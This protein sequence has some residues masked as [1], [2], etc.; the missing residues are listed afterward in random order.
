MLITPGN[1]RK[2]KELTSMI[3]MKTNLPGNNSSKILTKLKKLNGGYFDPYPFVHSNK[4]NGC[5]FQDIDGNKFLDFG[6]QIASNPLGYNH[7]ELKKVIKKYSNVHP[8]KY[9][10]QD[11]TVKEHLTLL[12][13]LL[14]ITPKE[15]NA[16]F[17]IN[18]GA[19]A[20]ENA[21]KICMRKREKAKFGI[22]FE[23]S[24]HGRCYDEETE[25][26]TEDGW[27]FFKDLKNDEK[28]ATLNLKNM[29]LEY[30]NPLAIVSYNY[31]GEMVKIKNCSMDL[32]VTPNHMMLISE[33]GKLK[34]C[35]A[36]NLKNNISIPRF[37]NW[38][39]AETECFTL[40][41]IEINIPLRNGMVYTQKIE[42]KIIPMDSW[43]KFFGIWLAEGW[44]SMTPKVNYSVGLAQKDKETCE[45]IESMLNETG[46]NFS[47]DV[48]EKGTQYKIR[49]GKQLWSYLEKFGGS[50]DKFIPKEIKNLSLRQLNILLEWM[51]FGD[52]TLDKSNRIIYFT[53]SK[54]LADD[55]QEIFLKIGSNARIY[56]RKRKTNYS[57]VGNVFYEVRQRKRANHV[58]Q[59]KNNP[60]SKFHYKGKVYC[61]E[62]QN[63]VIYV[64]RNG[65]PLWCGNSLGALSLTNSKK[66]Y[67]KNYL[68]IPTKTLPFSENA[69]EKLKSLLKNYSPDKIAFIIIEP[70]QGEGGYNV[71]PK[72]LINNLRKITKV[73]KI[74]LI[75][76]EVQSGMGRTGKWWAIENYNVTPEVISAAKTLQVGATIANRKFFPEPGA[77]SSTW[78]GGSLIDLAVGT[79]VIQII[80]KEKLLNNINKQGTYLRKRLHEL[81]LN[82]NFFNIRGLGLMNAFDLENKNIRNNLV[83]ECLK[84]GLVLL[85]CGEKGIRLIPPYIINQEE[86]D[87]G[88]EIVEKS[89]K[90]IN[91]KGF[92]NTGNICNYMNCGD[93]ST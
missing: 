16:A 45:K 54:R 61:C 93:Y 86:I 80:K 63:H 52:G 91:E 22:A 47:R 43:L 39:G 84:N 88:I 19:E 17:F 64:R 82:K 53:C 66:L 34:F 60:I 85:G 78:G 59:S 4:G 33:K 8:I 1:C 28:I 73:N 83:I 40:P 51:C 26:L 25:V 69:T 9:A 27:K 62:V 32:L 35:E 38:K 13:E 50:Y 70:V 37:A 68:K 56:W 46:F 55:I 6:S 44:T 49:G 3:E 48:R 29:F 24:F 79:K 87:E 81:S 18:S 67:T 90:K 23:K 76:D 2:L 57:S 92:K 89:Y 20:V 7:P 30:Q 42:E 74:P 15:L 36:S 75:S 21:I 5:Y 11:F 10:G 12:E 41:A 14:S 65:Y 58:I 31:N 77:I 72:N 71:A